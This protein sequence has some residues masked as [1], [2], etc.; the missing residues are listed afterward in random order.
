MICSYQ[1]APNSQGT[2]IEPQP[3][4]WEGFNLAG[5][6]LLRRVI[7]R[8]IL[9]QIA[10]YSF[11]INGNRLETKSAM[12]DLFGVHTGENYNIKNIRLKNIITNQLLLPIAYAFFDFV[13]ESKNSD[14]VGFEALFYNFPR[15]NENLIKQIN[16]RFSSITT[17]TQDTETS[18]DITKLSWYIDIEAINTIISQ[19][20][21]ELLRHISAIIT[22]F[23]CDI[24]L[25]AGNPTKLPVIK[26]IIIR[27]LPVF[28]DKIITL[29]NYRIGNWYPFSDARH[30]LKD[31]KTIVCVGAAIS[32]MSEQGLLSHI[33]F[34]TEPLKKINSRGFF[35]G[36]YISNNAKISTDD[37]FLNKEQEEN[38]LCLSNPVLTIG[39]R[40]LS[41]PDWRAAPI[42]HLGY[43]DKSAAAKLEIKGYYP[44][45]TFEISRSPMGIEELIVDTF[46]SDKDG[47]QFKFDDYFVLHPQSISDETGYWLDSGTFT[48][49]FIDTI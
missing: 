18:F 16:D 44:P 30:N 19:T 26:D 1:L 9:P 21:G 12:S 39:K 5:D 14:K 7:E 13:A 43:K 4:F 20:I 3:L 8:A 24:I 27:N 29:G 40:Q 33:R 41:N 32:H 10:D 2:V 25:L 11:K 37:V 49:D 35:I 31:P 48:I 42:Y 36:K 23:D 22:Q 45:F 34:N 15:P 38:Q 28:P 17:L 6:D 47:N 46:V